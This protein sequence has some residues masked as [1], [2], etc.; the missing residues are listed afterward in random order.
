MIEVE[1]LTKSYG[2]VH[3]VQGITFKVDAGEIVGFLGPNGAGK[4]TTMRIVTGFMPPTDG[5]VKID[6]FDVFEQS[7]DARRRIGYLPENPPVYPEMTVAEYLS[8]VAE[9]KDVPKKERRSRVDTVIG[10]LHLGEMR[11]RLIG[12]L[13]KG[14]RQRVGLAQA[15]VHEPK[16]LILD[17]PTI[18]LDPVQIVEIRNLI[19]SLAKD[20]T[21]IL[22]THILPEVS[23]LCQRVIII[24][25]GRIVAQGAQE[26]LI[27]RSGASRHLRV[28]VKGNGAAIEAS[29]AKVVGSGTVSRTSGTDEIHSFSLLAPEGQDI[30]ES[31]FK[32][33]VAGGW[34]LLELTAEGGS[35]EEVFMRLTTHEKGVEAVAA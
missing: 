13:S 25:S 8:F 19:K 5:T 22:S 6:G 3:A 15:L 9:L 29:L 11:E 16:V 2:P 17:E 21:V 12:H 10:Q 23:A 33:V 26:T 32:A 20:R 30:R 27:A 31:V 18:G 14:F 1:N 34:V 7:M 24:N 35:L 28:T 4:T